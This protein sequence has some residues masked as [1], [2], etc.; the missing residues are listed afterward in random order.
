[1]LFG[2]TGDQW[3]KSFRWFILHISTT[4]HSHMCNNLDFW[5]PHF[6]EFAKSIRA[7]L[8]TKAGVIYSPNFKVC[9][10]VDDTTFQTC[11]PQGSFGVRPQRVRYRMQGTFILVTKKCLA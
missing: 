8:K 5:Q 9:G 4:F 11:A 1:M 3:G 10:F 2:R 6:A 7:K